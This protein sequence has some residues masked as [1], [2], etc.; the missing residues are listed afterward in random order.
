MTEVLRGSFDLASTKVDCSPSR[1]VVASSPPVG[2]EAASW[3][4]RTR[5]FQALGYRFAAVTTDIGMGQVIDELYSACVTEDEPETWY[6]IYQLTPG[7]RERDMYVNSQRVFGFDRAS[8]LLQHLTWHVN[9]EVIS[10][11]SS[12]VLLHAAAAASDGHG[13][14]LAAP[15]EA[16]KTT[17]VAGLV[18]SGLA[19]VTDEAVAIDP[20]TLRIDPY[21]KP[22]TIDPGSWEIL[23]DLAPDEP[24]TSDAYHRDQWHVSP[25]T[26]RPDAV[27][28][29]VVP[30]VVVFPRFVEGAPTHI[31]PVR[32]SEALVTLLAQTFRLHDQ[33]ARNIEVLARTL[34]RTDCYRLRSGDLA[35]ACAAVRSVF[36]VG[37]GDGERKDAR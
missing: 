3:S 16:G 4:Y 14:V 17:L 11:S 37:R 23:A 10:R 35:E 12:Y 24:Q 1:R 5:T 18:R 22:L 15:A 28:G 36:G 8:R 20:G 21:P 19:Y 7:G 26:M 33:G 2:L 9:H 30:S 27:A 31:E 29:P 32:R 25:L 6:W 34:R 13:V